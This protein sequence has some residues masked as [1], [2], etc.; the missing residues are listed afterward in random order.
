MSKRHRPSLLGALLWISF[1]V[2]FLLMN[3]GIGLNFWSVAGRYWP[4]LLILLGLGKVI[5]YYLDKD[6]FSIRIGE[7]FGILLLLLVGSAM[8]RISESH[9]VR[10][11]RELPIEIGGTSVRPGQWIGDSHAYTEEATYPLDPAKPI[12][13]ENSYGLVAIAPGND[14]EVR[15]RLKKVVYADESRAKDIASEIRLE[16]G[17]EG[18]GGLSAE[19]KPEAKP[20][21]EPAA[22]P[23]AGVF[24]LRTNRESLSSKQYVFNTD[25]EVLIPKNSVVEV[26]NSFGEVRAANIDGSMNLSTTHRSLEIRDCTGQF[27]VSNRYGESRLTNLKGNVVLDSRGRARLEDIKGDVTVTNEYSPLQ[28]LNIEGKISISITE[29]NVRLEKAT[30]PVTIDARGSDVYVDDLKD[31]LKLTASHKNI[32]VSNVASNVTAETSYAT[33]ALKSIRGNVEIRSNSDSISADDI[34]GSLKL[35]GRASAVTVHEIRGPLDIQTTLKDVV[36]TDASDNCDIT[37]EYA[38]VSLAARS[39][40]KGGIRVINRNGAI[41]L[42]LPEGV[43]FVMDATSRNGDIESGY[44][45]LAPAKK[46]GNSSVL[47]STVKSGG[48]RI[49]LETEHDTIQIT[50]DTGDEQDRDKAKEETKTVL[51]L[52]PGHGEIRPAILEQFRRTADRIQKGVAR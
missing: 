16:A 44:S 10:F 40:G 41:D 17:M 46:E 20:E 29:N 38:D 47:K 8:T 13:I 42:S 4:V 2:L 27:T 5:D 28:L 15:V 6:A 1:G 52:R 34:G 21:A 36:V 48:P 14:R 30:G 50:G 3:L 9:F 24:V 31:S 39:L 32:E 7:I 11:V 22:K 35:K 49:L 25:M 33:L 37:N 19:A 26:R 45:G 18:Q 12:R 43:S 23:D 51:A